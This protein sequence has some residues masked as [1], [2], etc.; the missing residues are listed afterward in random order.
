MRYPACFGIGKAKCPT[1]GKNGNKLLE[2][3]AHF[4]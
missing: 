3:G 1:H 2:P 4:K